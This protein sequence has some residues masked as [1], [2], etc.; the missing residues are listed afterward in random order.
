MN[1]AEVINGLSLTLPLRLSVTGLWMCFI[2]AMNDAVPSWAVMA[3]IAFVWQQYVDDGFVA[4]PTGK[5]STFDC[6]CGEEET[7]RS[8]SLPDKTRRI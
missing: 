4:P 2:L 8:T 5:G 1:I 3:M 7:D 6:F